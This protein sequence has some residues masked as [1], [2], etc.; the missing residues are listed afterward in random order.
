MEPSNFIISSDYPIDKIVWL[1]QGE[2]TTNS[3]GSWE[4]TIPHKLTARP[5]VKGVWT[6]NDWATTWTT[7][8]QQLSGQSYTNSSQ[9]ASDGTNVYFSGYQE[10]AKKKV[11]Y[12]L[13]GVWNEADT[14]SNEANPTYG[15]SSNRLIINTD[16]KYPKLIAEG[17]LE[18]NKTYTHSLG[19][20]PYVEIWSYREIGINDYQD[21][22]W[23]WVQHS[24]DQFGTIYGVTPQVQITDTT[25]KVTNTSTSPSK[26]YYRIYA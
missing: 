17:Y 10:T 13:W 24:E 12:K 25:I 26:I 6:T 4:L 19:Y 16:L 1:Y 14:Y 2:V 7:G 20:I 22:V 21:T 15:M 23:A 9:V 8:S 11:K 3:Y 5:Y 18:K